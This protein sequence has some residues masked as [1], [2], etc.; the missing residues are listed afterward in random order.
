[1]PPYRRRCA[2]SRG[3]L[4]G[5]VPAADPAAMNASISAA[6]KP[7]VRNGSVTFASG[8]GSVAGDSIDMVLI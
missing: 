8:L 7:G 4:A 5:K 6:L 3:E 2:E 1:V